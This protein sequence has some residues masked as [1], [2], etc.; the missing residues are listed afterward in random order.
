MGQTKKKEVDII[1][2]NHC[3]A[4][5]PHR[6]CVKCMYC[7]H[8]CWGGIARMKHHLAGTCNFFIW[9][10]EDANPLSGSENDDD[11]GAEEKKKEK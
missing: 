1:T 8:T 5:P 10:D 7:S 6:L 4:V 3:E 9:V 11:V 2:W